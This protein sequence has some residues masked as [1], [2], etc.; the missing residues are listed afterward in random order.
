MISIIT[1]SYN[2]SE[3]LFNRLISAIAHLQSPFEVFEWLIVDN[4]STIPIKDRFDF[5]F[6]RHR[7]HFINEKSQGLTN[8]RIAG[9]KASSGKW[10]IFL[11]DDNEP[12]PDFIIELVKGI[13]NHPQVT[14]WGPGNIQVEF[15]GGTVSSWF[16]EHKEY[17]QERREE[18]KFDNR[19]YMQACYPIGTGLCIKKDCMESYIEA[20]ETGNYSIKDRTG[21]SLLSGGDTQI[22]LHN[23]KAGNFSGK[24]K[25]LKLTHM[26]EARKAGYKYLKKQKYWTA[27]SYKLVLKQVYGDFDVENNTGFNYRNIQNLIR[28]FYY[29]IKV[30]RKDIKAS[31]L[32]VCSRLGEYNANVVAGHGKKNKL[33]SILEKLLI[34]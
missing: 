29:E 8:A 7:V 25:Q 28:Q 33:F 12:A 1:C 14:C 27:S 17:Y 4:N 24:L 23:Q 30:N 31:Y 19:K 15:V 26:I 32:V 21:Q 6:I 2:P 18:T 11:D 10:L 34:N 13:E 22:V 5:S 16:T 20:V 9:S 3:L